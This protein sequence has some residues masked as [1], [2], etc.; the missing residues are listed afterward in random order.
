M[1]QESDAPQDESPAEEAKRRFRE[2]LERNARNARAQ[3]A[4]QSRTKIQG[5]SSGAGGGQKRTRRKAG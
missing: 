4:H 1:A 3:Q 2:A 5:I